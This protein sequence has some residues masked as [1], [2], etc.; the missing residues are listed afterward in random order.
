MDF[1]KM[2]MTHKKID[3]NQYRIRV[4][5]DIVEVKT[6]FDYYGWYRVS[7]EQHYIKF[8]ENKPTNPNR[9]YALREYVYKYME[10]LYQKELEEDLRVIASLPKAKCLKEDFK[11]HQLRF[12]EETT[13]FGVINKFIDSYR[14]CL[15]VVD[16]PY[17]V[18]K[19]LYQNTDGFLSEELENMFIF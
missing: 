19:E 1:S 15:N 18:L 17:D 4:G 6:Y 7:I 14:S 13:A 2:K 9:T 5:N 16:D 8:P 12:C 10:K 11:G 3:E